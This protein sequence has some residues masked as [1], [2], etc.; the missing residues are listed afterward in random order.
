[1]TTAIKKNP[2]SVS[3]VAVAAMVLLGGMSSQRVFADQDDVTLIRVSSIRYRCGGGEQ[4]LATYY[5]LLDRSLGFVRLRIPD[6]RLLT[7]PSVMSADG[8]RFSTDRDFTWWIK[9]QSGFLQQRDSEGAWRITVQNCDPE[10][11]QLS[12]QSSLHLKR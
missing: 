1:M 4:L 7:L 9:G 8:E 5:T 2:I 11:E 3:L 10:S 6:G 12:P